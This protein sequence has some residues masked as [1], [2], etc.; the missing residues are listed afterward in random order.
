MVTFG[1]QIA[2]SCERSRCALSTTRLVLGVE[3]GPHVAP[4]RVALHR[5][6]QRV[7]PVV[8]DPDLAAIGLRL[9]EDVP[10]DVHARDVLLDL[11]VAPADP[12]HPDDVRDRVARAAVVERVGQLGPDVLLE[13]G[14]VGVVERLEQL[15]RDQVD[16]VRAAQAH[17]QV[18]AHRPGREL[19]D[20]LVGRVVGRDLDLRVELLLEL[21]DRRRVDVVGVVVDPQRAGLGLDAVRDRLVVVG[22][23]PGHRVVGAWQREARGAER[24]GD[25]ELRRGLG[26]LAR[27]IGGADR[28]RRVLTARE[29]PAALRPTAATADR[30]SSW[31]RLMPDSLGCTFDLLLLR[32]VNYAPWVIALRAG[33]P[34]DLTAHG[35]SLRRRGRCD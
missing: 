19:R 26:D 14:Q 11:V 27:G 33:K 29:G 24:L 18:E 8:E 28:R 10:R 2:L 1:L 35:A 3:V 9:P 20:R 21:L 5:H 13:V 12:V 22:D 34:T 15:A 32:S 16:D 7:A 25:D 30:R 17:D 23:R 31:R 4:H 6:A